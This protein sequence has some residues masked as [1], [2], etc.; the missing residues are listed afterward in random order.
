MQCPR[1]YRENQPQAVFCLE[2]GARLRLTCAKCHAELPPGAK[3]C[4]A[5]GEPVAHAGRF[6]SPES[7]TPKHLAEKILTSKAALANERKQVTVLFADLKASMERLADRDSEE[8]LKVLDPVLERMMGA[9]HRY[10]G[11]VNQVMGDGIMA[12]FGAPLAL[13]D[14]AIRACYAALRMQESIRQYSEEV[15]RAGGGPVH[16]RVGLN[17]GEVVVRSIG[18]DLRMDYTAVGPS[19]HLAARMEQI[20]VP[21]SVLITGATLALVEGYVQVREMGAR[22]VKGLGYP[23]EVYEL[24]GPTAVRSRFHVAAARGLTRF[25]GRS[26]ELHQLS[27]SAGRARTGHGQVVAVIGEPG[28]GKS[29]LVWEFVHSRQT[30]GFLVLES[31]SASYG[32]ATSYLPVIGLLKTYF[33]IEAHDDAGK[34]REKVTGKLHSAADVL[35][36]A[37]LPLLRLLDVPIED[38]EWDRLDPAQRRRRTLEALRGLFLGESRVQPLLLIF[39]D[40]HWIDPETQVVLDGLVES[41]PT[42][43]L[44]I[45]VNYRREYQHP[46]SGQSHYREIRV[47]PLP[48]PSAT[49]LLGAL[50]GDGPELAPLKAMLIKRTEGNPLFIEESVRTLVE[51]RILTGER[52]AYALTKTPERLEIPATVQA[53]LA[54]RIDRLAPADKRLLQAASVIGTEVPFALLQEIGGGSESLLLESLA[55]L[56][57]GEFLF[58]SR[59]FPDVEYSFKHALTHEVAYGGLL[60]GRRRE[61]HARIVGAIESLYRD[62]LSEQVERLAHHARQGEMWKKAAHYFHQAGLQALARSANRPAA[63]FLEQAIAALAWLPESREIDEQAIDLRFDLRNALT[64]LGAASRI[65]EHLREAEALAERLGDARRLGRARSF[66]TNALYLVGDYRAAIE[67]GHRAQAIAEALDDFALRT[68]TQMYLGRAHESLGGYRE[69]ARIYGRTVASLSGESLHEQLGLPVL[70]AVFARSLLVSALTQLGEFAEAGPHADQAAALAEATRQPDNLFWAYRAAALI[71]LGLEASSD[72]ASI[73]DR[74]LA[75]CRASD[76][77]TYVAAASSDLGLAYTHTGRLE[78]GLRLLEFG[79]MQTG[80]R[81]QWYQ[82]QAILQL[83]EGY[84]A[85]GRDSEAQESGERAL[86]LTRER[87]ERG[88]EAHA[89]RLLGDVASRQGAAGRDRALDLYRSA[90]ALAEELGMRPCAARCRLGVGLVSSQSGDRAGA[91]VA[92]A[93]AARAMESMAMLASALRARHALER[94]G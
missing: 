42:A 35:E 94:I 49:E 55:R 7:Y 10:E 72:A 31:G 19:T 46:W 89:L 85:A 79:A 58:E 66:M 37:R 22:R 59:L 17:S 67:I 74:A 78:E 87:R 70:P 29:R 2:C 57:A 82:P 84:L 44:L 12:L 83:G 90:L 48:V 21:G 5:C 65:L 77:T 38:A 93:E 56:C 13:E 11:T 15:Q 53:L 16:I 28:V 62:R 27:Q 14:H 25:V 20:A 36:P 40:L 69:A 73:L 47:D 63:A 61:L 4:F 80:A 50:L 86:Q 45:L 60:H 8:A 51:T 39:E 3:F 43:R 81:R 92:L 6:K 24:L 9:V 88:R 52:G 41:L 26:E 91:R 1:C 18:S 64:P 34:I 23:V 75:V 30:E 32:Q 33:Q 76:L 68:A 54:A 71:R